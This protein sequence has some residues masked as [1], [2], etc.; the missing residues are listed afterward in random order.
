MAGPAIRAWQMAR[1]LGQG[2]PIRLAVPGAPPDLAAPPGVSYHVYQRF[3]W[4]SLSPAVAGAKVVV[5]S[6]D[7]AA[8]FPGLAETPAAIVIDGYDPTLAESLI[9]WQGQSPAD[10]Q[11][12]WQERMRL[13]G[14]Q[15]EMGDFF[16]CA[17]ERQRDWW[18]GQLEAT[19]RVNPLTA[20]QDPSLRQ[21]VDVVPFGLDPAPIVPGPPVVRGVWP[22]IGVDDEIVVWGGG[23]W[24]WLDPLMAI[25]AV[26]RLAARRPALRLIFPGTRHPNPAMD[27]VPTLVADAITLARELA[28]LDRHV[29]FGDW[30][31]AEA[32]PRLLRECN[33]ALTLHAQ[34]TYESRLA[35]RSRVLDYIRVALP[36]VATAG[37]AT[38]DLLLEHGVGHVVPPGDLEAVIDA[39]ELGLRPLSPAAQAGF[40]VLRGRLNWESVCAP[41]L[42]YC[43]APVRAAD[44]VGRARS[45][46]NPYGL[47]QMAQAMAPLQTAV[48]AYEKIK[49]VRAVR[50]LHPHR[51]RLRRWLRGQSE[52]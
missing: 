19:G 47:D 10:Q 23:L 20:A 46:G 45:P 18:L 34:E 3:D 28:V 12:L 29:F 31:A 8:E 44:R 40:D 26:A 2:Q 16:L 36:V 32:W 38:A 6:G 48:A 35:F 50:W 13:L 22:G 49:F 43:R 7:T 9:L 27:A 1:V 52:T 24:L 21:L 39:I 42:R 51:Q 17:S 37:D 25:R 14:P 5:A 30:V 33:L 41:L 4:A 15:F 11:R